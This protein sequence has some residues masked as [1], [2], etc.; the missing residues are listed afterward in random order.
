MEAPEQL[1]EAFLAGLQFGVLDEGYFRGWVGKE[2][3]VLFL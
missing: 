3:L 2:V 1:Q